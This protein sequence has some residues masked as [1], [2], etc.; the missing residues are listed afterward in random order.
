[1]LL[2]LLSR[3]IKKDLTQVFSNAL[4]IQNL[5]PG[6][7]LDKV[8]VSTFILRVKEKFKQ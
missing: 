4:Q 5:L 6:P 3:M 1:M 2:H 7:F 8:Q